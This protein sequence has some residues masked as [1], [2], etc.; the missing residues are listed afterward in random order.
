MRLPCF[1]E[2][3]IEDL[4]ARKEAEVLRLALLTGVVAREDVE[5]WADG[6]LAELSEPNHRLIEFSLAVMSEPLAL[7]STRLRLLGGCYQHVE[8]LRRVLGRMAVLTSST[9]SLAETF[10]HALYALYCGDWWDWHD[11]PD[12]LQ[13]MAYADEPFRMAGTGHYECNSPDEVN[14]WFLSLVDRFSTDESEK[15]HWWRE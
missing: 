7:L 5:E 8:A 3:P 12:D 13:F 6:L 14:G 1:D 2:E 4:Q 15:S 9:P 11:L 10:A